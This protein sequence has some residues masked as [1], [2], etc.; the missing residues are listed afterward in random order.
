MAS[1]EGFV[2][3]SNDTRLL[4]QMC[5]IWGS[6]ESSLHLRKRQVEGLSPEAV[7][8]ELWTAKL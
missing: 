4:R 2:M 6:L 8:E 3:L 1:A 7:L 5:E